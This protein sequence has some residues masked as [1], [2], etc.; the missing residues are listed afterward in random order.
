MPVYDQNGN[1]IPEDKAVYQTAT[2]GI[3]KMRV[4]EG[5]NP[6]VYASIAEID[7]EKWAFF[8]TEEALREGK[9]LAFAQTLGEL[10]DRVQE[11]LSGGVANALRTANA[12]PSLALWVIGGIVILEIWQRFGKR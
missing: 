8:P 9:I 7:G 2:P 3:V 10:P 1:A 4:K 5:D 6:P 11:T 12:L